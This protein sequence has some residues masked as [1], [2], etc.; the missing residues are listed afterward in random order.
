MHH[1]QTGNISGVSMNEIFGDPEAETIFEHE[2][3][4]FTEELNNLERQL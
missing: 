4:T 3:A 1:D 2:I